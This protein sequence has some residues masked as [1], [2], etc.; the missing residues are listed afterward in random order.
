MLLQ[1]LLSYTKSPYNAISKLMASMY[2]VAASL[3]SVAASTTLSGGGIVII[4]DQDRSGIHIIVGYTNLSSLHDG[5]ETVYCEAI[6]RCLAGCDFTHRVSKITTA[7]FQSA[8][9][10]LNGISSVRSRHAML[11]Y[12]D[13][14]VWLYTKSGPAF[15]VDLDE[16]LRE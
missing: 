2:S 3:C 4:L 7:K 6:E 13:E 8:P 16:L 11:I 9:R 1:I 14:V 5:D 12:W 15:E 10:T